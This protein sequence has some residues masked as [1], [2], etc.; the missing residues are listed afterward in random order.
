MKN[1]NLNAIYRLNTILT[2]FQAEDI[3]YSVKEI[4]EILNIPIS[5]VREDIIMLHIHEECGITFYAEDDQITE[6]VACLLKSGKG[7]EIYLCANVLYRN[8]V[9]LPLSELEVSCLNDFLDGKQISVGKISRN[10][11]IKPLYNQA[12]ANMQIKVK[13]M[14]DIIQQ[15]KTIFVRYKTREGDS[16]HLTICPLELVHNAMEDLYYVITIEK[17]KLL[18]L[19]L[20]RIRSFK[21]AK[22]KMKI[23]DRSALEELSQIWGMEM[24]EKVHVK[25]KILNEANVAHKVKRDLAQRVHGVWS[26]KGEELYFEDDVIG[27]HN[28]R[29]WVNSYGSS[30]LVI[31][32]ESLR[33]EIM[34]SARKRIAYYEDV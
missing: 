33:K 8:E 9:Y 18:A 5:V 30:V 34:D 24:G 26:Q 10:Y 32:P 29:S 19:R 27:I 15:E 16:L 28:F 12:R 21:E 23:E 17:G 31:E 22:K 11:V 13:E 14:N 7:D 2:M 25:I 1:N 20:D 4:S 3:S 6:D